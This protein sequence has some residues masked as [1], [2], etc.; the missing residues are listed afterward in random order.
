MVII[1]TMSNIIVI[2]LINAFSHL[3]QV[4]TD[5]ECLMFINCI[6]CKLYFSHSIQILL[7]REKKLFQTKLNGTI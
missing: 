2:D 7:V 1:L 4:Y 5:F 6:Y 3:P